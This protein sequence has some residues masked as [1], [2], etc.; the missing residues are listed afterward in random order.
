MV[1][2]M[3]EVSEK[4]ESKERDKRRGDS[5][6][7]MIESATDIHAQETDGEEKQYAIDS[8]QREVRNSMPNTIILR[9][10]N[11][12]FGCPDDCKPQRCWYQA[13]RCV[14]DAHSEKAVQCLRCI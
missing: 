14:I 4:I 13:N 11:I 7:V 1:G 3:P 9:A 8:G 10:G 5:V 6:P 12:R 2:S